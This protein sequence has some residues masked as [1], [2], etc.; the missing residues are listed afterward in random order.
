MKQHGRG[1]KGGTGKKDHIGLNLED[2]IGKQP[3]EEAVAE[4]RT[5]ISVKE[6]RDPKSP[7]SSDIAASTF[8]SSVTGDQPV[9]RERS[10]TQGPHGENPR[11]TQAKQG[12]RGRIKQASPS[13]LT[14]SPCEALVV[15][16]E[17]PQANIW[18]SSCCCLHQIAFLPADPTV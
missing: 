4:P 10:L 9:L 12:Q 3:R 5:L 16:T 1:A 14:K 17:I 13:D 11:G 8:T 6:E 2:N 15:K 18:L 7:P